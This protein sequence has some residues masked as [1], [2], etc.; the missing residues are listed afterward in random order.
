[1]LNCWPIVHGILNILPHKYIPFVWKW[2]TYFL[3]IRQPMY[4]KGN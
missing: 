4:F 1:M 2:H 3:E